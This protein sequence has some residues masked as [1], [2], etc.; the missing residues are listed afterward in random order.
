MLSRSGHWVLGIVTASGTT[1]GE[2]VSKTF[3]GGG[4]RIAHERLLFARR[5]MTRRDAMATLAAGLWSGRSAPC[6]NSTIPPLDVV[7]VSVFVRTK[8]GRI[9]HNLAKE[10]FSIEESGWRQTIRH[11]SG[12]GNLPLT[13]GLLIDSSAA[14]RRL[15]DGQRA[16][17]YA[18][19]DRILRTSRGPGL[20]ERAFVVEFDSHLNFKQD[21]TDSSESIEKAL[22]PSGAGLENNPAAGIAM[23]R[24]YDA[25]VLACEERMKW[26]EGQKACIVVTDGIDYGSQSTLSDAI[27]SAQSADSLIYTIQYVD[28]MGQD[29]VHRIPGR[30]ANYVDGRIVLQRMAQETGGA[31]YEVTKTHGLRDIYQEIE[32]ELRSGYSLEYV[33]EPFVPGY[34]PIHI[35]VS[36]KDMI[37]RARKGYYGVARSAWLEPGLRITRIDHPLHATPGDV[38][39]AIGDGLSRS[40]IGALYLT[41]GTRTVESVVLHQTANEIRFRIPDQAAPGPWIAGEKRPHIWR[42]LLQ[43]S[44]QDLLDFVSFPIGIE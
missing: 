3:V 16:A 8:D 24:L 19:L 14:Q 7:N 21:L 27:S 37:V 15:L 42:I 32:E 17:G 35:T 39:T 44:S 9:V 10:D 2:A 4:P 31:Y 26:V 18:F 1:W 33:A 41:D 30:T 22:A 38:V 5:A 25:L 13:V 29:T 36:D 23:T 34:R 12:T 43:T 28:L 20:R 11:F 6:Q 40:N